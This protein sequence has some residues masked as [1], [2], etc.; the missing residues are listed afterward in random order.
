MCVSSEK[1]I[2]CVYSL[3]SSNIVQWRVLM[4]HVHLVVHR[5]KGVLCGSV[6]FYT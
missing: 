2:Y 4:I 3:I 6:Q 5:D 1:H